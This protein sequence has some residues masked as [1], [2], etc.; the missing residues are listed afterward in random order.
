MNNN[1]ISYNVQ[2]HNKS[3]VVLCMISSPLLMFDKSA[4]CDQ[5]T[6]G[7][8]KALEASILRNEVCP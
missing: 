2:P 5:D 8:H 3:I 7:L 1:D 4:S 6:E